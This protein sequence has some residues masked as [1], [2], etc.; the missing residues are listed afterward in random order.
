MLCAVLP[1]PTPAITLP[2]WA[3]APCLAARIVRDFSRSVVEMD[4]P[5][6]PLTTTESFQ[7][8]RV[9][10]AASRSVP[11]SSSRPAWSNGVTMAVMTRPNAAE[12]AFGALAVV[13]SVSNLSGTI[14][15]VLALQS[16]WCD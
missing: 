15:I 4:S 3:A 10:Q 16:W 2:P 5:V 12:A 9:S 6:V 1:V 11:R 14:L 13:E 8:S 7:P